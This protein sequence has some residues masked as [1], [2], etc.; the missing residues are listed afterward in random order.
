MKHLIFP[1][2]LFAVV[3][4]YAQHFLTIGPGFSHASYDANDMQNFSDTYT[5]FHQEV[6][7]SPM[8]GI[9]GSEGLRFEIG[10]RYIDIAETNYGVM[11]GF[12]TFNRRNNAI[13]GNGEY[14]DLK[15]TWNSFYTDFEIGRTWNIFFAN[16]LLSFN[17]KKGLKLESQYY[18]AFKQPV[19]KSLNGTYENSASFSAAAGLAIGFYREWIFMSFKITHHL[20]TTNRD[21]VFVD[22]NREKSELGIEKFPNDFNRYY[23]REQYDGI[24]NEFNKLQFSFN[25][26]VAIPLGEE[27]GKDKR[28]EVK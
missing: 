3:P 25:I 18:D 10:Y 15:L 12:Q 24:S 1:L 20:F 6:L 17:F 9:D 19:E 7:R 4:L 11:I 5:V 14:R 26:A 23:G 8:E 28:Q 16:G 27:N 22:N 2:L 13:F 21:R